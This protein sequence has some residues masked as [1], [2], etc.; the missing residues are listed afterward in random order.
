MLRG[1]GAL[2][3][4][5]HHATYYFTPSWR[6]GTVEWFDPGR[7][8]VL[9]FFLVSGYIIPASL[10]RRGRV[11]DFWIGRLLR[12]HPLLLTMCAITVLPYVL[13]VRG[14]RAGLDQHDPVTAIVAHALMLQDVLAVPNGI[15]VLW[16]LSYEMAFY[17]LVVAV[18]VSTRPGL[19]HR[20]SV[21]LALLPAGLA[22]LVGGVLP[23]T[24]L[25]RTF[26]VGPVV[27]GTAVLLVISIAA[28]ASNRPVAR[29]SGGVLGGSV[30]L[31]L[32]MANGRIAP[33]EGLTILA[34]MFLGTVLYR[35]EHRQIGPAAAA[36][37]AIVVFAAAIIAGVLH[38]G[39]PVGDDADFRIYWSGSV[40]VAAVTFAIGWALRHRRMPRALT[41]LGV[42]SFSV[43]LL[44]PVLLML[45]DQAGLRPRAD[46]PLGLLAFVVVMIAASW[47]TYRC[48][49]LP[50]QRLGRRITRPREA[51]DRP[52]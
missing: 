11:G 51:G 6:H 32:V 25:T 26:G 1:V 8:G 38:S 50:G 19:L 23:V 34:V 47:V 41:G 14:L 24:L 5:L 27:A 4:A 44:H 2:A 43:Y 29:V 15:N 31:I 35:A 16:T 20:S 46:S 30:A 12:I 37:T 28:A 36:V 22:L 3:V 39:P 21:P 10:E 40:V 18:F 42:I 33:W 9:V 52:A 48:I 45:W 7:A 13:G 17:L 49:E